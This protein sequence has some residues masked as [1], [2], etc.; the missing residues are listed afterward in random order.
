SDWW[1]SAISIRRRRLVLRRPL[2]DLP[3][4]RHP[5]SRDR[6]GAPGE[7]APLRS[8]R[9]VAGLRRHRADADRA[10]PPVAPQPPAA[11]QGGSGRPLAGGGRLM[12]AVL[13]IGIGVLAGSGLWLAL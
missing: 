8:R 6:R 11:C 10:G 5:P 3:V 4:G 7:R 9:A 12:E 2:P 1:A 13:A